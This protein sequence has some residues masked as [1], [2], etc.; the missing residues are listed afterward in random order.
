MG[1][2]LMSAFGPPPARRLPFPYNC[3]FNKFDL[4]LLSGR[5]RRSACLVLR[6]AWSICSVSRPSW[7]TPAARRLSTTSTTRSYLRARVGLHEH[8]LVQPVGQQILD[9]GGRSSGCIWPWCSRYVLPS[10]VIAQTMASLLSAACMA[11]GFLRLHHFHVDALRQHRRDDH[12]DDQHDEHHV[13]H[14]RDV[15]VGYR[16]RRF[17]LLFS[18]YAMVSLHWRPESAEAGEPC[19]LP[20]SNQLAGSRSTRSSTTC[21]RRAANASGSS[22]STRSWSSPS[23]RRTLRSCW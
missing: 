16:R 9:L 20:V 17:V 12:E 13:H 4:L 23:P 2:M 19:G 8:R 11:I 22:R 3:S 21:G 18:P 10:R 15:D 14:R 5:R 6:L 1:V 7:S